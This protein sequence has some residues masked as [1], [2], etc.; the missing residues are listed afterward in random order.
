MIEQFIARMARLPLVLIYLIIGAGAAVENVVP[1]IPA[2][3]FVLLGAFIA[4]RG[5]GNPW[6]VFLVTWLCNII[7]VAIVYFVADEYGESFFMKPI[8]HWLIHPKQM[9][10]IDRFY[11]RW[12]VPA[13]FVSRFL[14]TLR[15]IVPVFAGVTH[16]PFLRVFVPVATAS[17]LWY[18]FVVYVGVKAGDN[19]QALSNFFDRFSGVL[20][21]VAGVIIVGL[22]AW[23][24][25]TRR[26]HRKR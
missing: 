3:T 11:V 9:E 14:P 24:W 1:P 2:D 22:L 26:L 10:Q 4:A 15:A 23:W 18:G 13:I 21:I 8:G 17:G 12:G 16:V 20:G 25:H 6:I 19:W 5:H 7:S